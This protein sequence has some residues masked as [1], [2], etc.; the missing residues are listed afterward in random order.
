MSTAILAFLGRKGWG[1]ILTDC[2][3]V[4]S[5]GSVVLSHAILRA[6]TSPSKLYIH[7][8]ILHL[9]GSIILSNFQLKL[10]S[11]KPK[12][13]LLSI[14]ST[15]FFIAAVAATPSTNE[16]EARDV[17]EVMKREV[18]IMKRAVLESPSF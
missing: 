13:K 3:V 17:H 10:L 15:A 16:A 6:S 2:I 8:L 14:L 5:S 18:E 11:T 9:Q 7:L 4:S 12:M 1:N